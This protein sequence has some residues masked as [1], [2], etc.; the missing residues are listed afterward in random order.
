MNRR[1]IIA[2]II[3]VA[4][5]VIYALYPRVYKYETSFY[6]VFDT[7]STI[8]LYWDNDKE[9]QSIM[10]EVHEELIRLNELY[11][12]YNNY[13][14]VNN[15]KTIN[16][17]AGIAPVKV[18]EDTMALLNFATQAY[19]DTKG[20]VNPMM[21][22]VLSIWHDHRTD[23]LENPEN[24]SLPNMEELKKAKEHTSIDLLILNK[25]DS[26]AYITDSSASLDVGAMA[27]GF[28]ADRAVEL[29]KEKGVESAMLNLGGNI[30]TIGTRDWGKSWTIG[31]TDPQNTYQSKADISAVNMSVVTSGSYQR[32]YEVKGVKYNHIIDPDTLMP[33]TRYASVTVAAESSATADM[34]STALFILPED[35][36]N[37]LAESYGASVCRIYDDGR[38]EADG[39][40]NVN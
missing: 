8:T 23:A 18:D 4:G 39:D 38:V 37:N 33:A 40:F 24:A 6:D 26:T 27:K 5:I 25:E 22:S 15:L 11:D 34:L 9:A 19:Y 12:I 14:G 30:C 2:L 1:I 17:N 32:Y 29:L 20:A 31:I 13:D 21:G 35:E 7:Y 3:A 10:D 28:A 36:G 16:D